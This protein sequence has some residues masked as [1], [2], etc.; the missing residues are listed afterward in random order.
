L[1][2]FIRACVF[3]RIE[4]AARALPPA[5]QIYALAVCCFAGDVR[6]YETNSDLRGPRC[7]GH[8]FALL[9]HDGPARRDGGEHLDRIDLAYLFQVTLADSR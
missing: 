3:S 5:A 4:L 7:F 2:Q 9:V 6:A 8:R 1:R